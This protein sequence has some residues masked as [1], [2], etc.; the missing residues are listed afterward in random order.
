MVKRFNRWRGVR[1]SE[2]AARKYYT[3]K[4]N[5]HRKKIEH[6]I[7]KASKE[8]WCR[9]TYAFPIRDEDRRRSMKIIIKTMNKIE[10]R[11]Y[12]TLHAKTVER[13]VGTYSITPEEHIYEISWGKAQS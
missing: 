6:L 9:I 11:G 8:G 5:E 4:Y 13:Q 10:S 2:R 3:T 7:H 12:R 1:K